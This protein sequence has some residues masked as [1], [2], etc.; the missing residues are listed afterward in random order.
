M[1]GVGS[2]K[3]NVAYP[4]LNQLPKAVLKHGDSFEQTYQIQAEGSGNKILAIA[5]NHYGN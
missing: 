3:G 1:K 2:F 5:L 4:R